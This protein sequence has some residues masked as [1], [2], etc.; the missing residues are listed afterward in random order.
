MKNKLL[1]ALGFALCLGLIL[2]FFLVLYQYIRDVVDFGENR[3]S[4]FAHR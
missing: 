3:V 2:L 4:F 1:Y